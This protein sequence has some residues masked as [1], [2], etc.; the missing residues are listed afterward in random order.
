MPHRGVGVKAGISPSTT[1]VIYG[2]RK[3]QGAGV[4][5][6]PALSQQAYALIS[7]GSL[8]VIVIAFITLIAL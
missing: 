2:H 1:I 7:S 6:P 3:G 5:L 4:N 8:C